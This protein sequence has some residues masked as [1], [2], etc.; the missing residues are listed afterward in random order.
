LSGLPGEPEASR[1]RRQRDAISIFLSPWADSVGKRRLAESLA[2]EAPFPSFY[3]LGRIAWGIAGWQSA[4]PDCLGNR[5]LAERVTR[6]R[7]FPSFFL[8]WRILWEREP[9]QRDAI[10]IFLSPWAG[11]VGNR[12]LAQSASPE[13]GHFHLSFSLGEFC[14]EAQAGREPRQRGAISIFLSPGPDCPGNCKLADSLTRE[15]PFPSF[16]L[17]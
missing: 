16:F 10:S 14:R 2:R 6:Q 8:L 3:L 11:C 7:P 5:K 13:R 17:L 9:H 1:A 4:S 15:A 12:K